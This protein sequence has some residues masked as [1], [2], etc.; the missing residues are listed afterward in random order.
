M[1]G[2][3]YMPGA[4]QH[5][6]ARHELIAHKT[7]VTQLKAGDQITFLRAPRPDLFARRTVFS[8]DQGRP[9]FP[10]HPAFRGI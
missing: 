2:F 7:Q 1:I 9:V 8:A 6:V 10:I 4:E 5:A 3:C